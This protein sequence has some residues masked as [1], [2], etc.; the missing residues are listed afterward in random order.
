MATITAEERE[1]LI[2]EC[3]DIDYQIANEE[4]FSFEDIL[5]NGFKGYKNY[6][7]LDLISIHDSLLDVYEETFGFPYDSDD[8]ISDDDDDDTNFLPLETRRL[9]NNNHNDND[10]GDISNGGDYY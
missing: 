6:D 7:N 8:Y 4:G 1:R 3:V 2:K 5:E 10:D 9:I